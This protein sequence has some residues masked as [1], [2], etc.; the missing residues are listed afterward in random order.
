VSQALVLIDLQNDYLLGGAFPPAA[1]SPCV[2]NPAKVLAWARARGI[3]VIHVQ[4]RELDPAVG[5][6]LDGS[7]GAET[8]MAVAP[9]DRE[10]VVVSV[11]RTLS[12]PPN[13]SRPWR[14]SIRWSWWGR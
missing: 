3:R 12:G 10:A 7:A 14:A 9:S 6:L 8:H 4:H 13:W 11:T 5:F 1:I 2:A